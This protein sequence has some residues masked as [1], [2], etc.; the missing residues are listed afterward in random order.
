MS[1]I[2]NI[3]NLTKANDL[4]RQVLFTGQKSQLV[5]MAIP[6][7]GEIG[8]ETH[9]NVEQTLFFLSGHGETILNGQRSPIA[10]GDVVIVT[11]GT[12]HNFVNTGTEPLKVYTLYAPPNHIDGRTHKT[13]ADAD[14]DEEDEEFGHG[15]K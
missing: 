12:E 15:V 1:Y 14:A 5:V 6:P 8:K 10:P 4:F 3:I 13:K 9:P 2:G 7:G 11:P